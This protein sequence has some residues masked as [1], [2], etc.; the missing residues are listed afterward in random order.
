MRIYIAEDEPLAA[1][2]LKLFLEKAGVDGDISIY[3]DGKKLQEAIDAQG[4]PDVIF[5]DIQMPN[6]TGLEF[7]QSLNGIDLAHRPDIIVTSAYDQYA[8]DGFNYGVTDYLLKPYTLERLK[9]SLTKLHSKS[10]PKP[11]M[12]NSVKSI[13]IRCDGRVERVPFTKIVCVEAV[14]DYTTFILSDKRKL[15]A[16][17]SLGVFEQQLPSDT[18]QRIQRSYI[19]NLNHVQSFTSLSVRM[20]TGIEVPLGKTYRDA[21]EAKINNELH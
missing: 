2:K 17:G 21:F 20:I 16:L 11:T 6:L 4:L 13:N 10:E 15:T 12:E 19:V 8:I 5:L 3:S 9:L 18:F 7:L 14:K 1:A